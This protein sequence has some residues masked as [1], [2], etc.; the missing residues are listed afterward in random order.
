MIIKVMLLNQTK[1]MCLIKTALHDIIYKNSYL[2]KANMNHQNQNTPKQT[3]GFQK[4][5]LQNLE[6]RTSLDDE[7]R[8]RRDVA[9][10]VEK[11]ESQM[12]KLLT[13]SANKETMFMDKKEALEEEKRRIEEELE[14]FS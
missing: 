14:K 13:V 11:L 6:L 9:K 12:E 10:R 3:S 4:V 7:I 2:D 1:N 5:R 8:K